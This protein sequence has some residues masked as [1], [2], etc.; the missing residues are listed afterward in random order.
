M[1][2]ERLADECVACESESEVLARLL[3]LEGSAMGAEALFG[4]C[5][6]VWARVRAR[7]GE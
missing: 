5:E 1:D 3:E 7:R 2:E 6:R 4:L